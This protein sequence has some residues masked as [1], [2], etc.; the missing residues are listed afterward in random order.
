MSGKTIIICFSDLSFG[1]Q[2]NFKKAF[3]LIQS[4]FQAVD[5][6]EII[7]TEALNFNLLNH[8][9]DCDNLI[10]I[11]LSN[12]DFKSGSVQLYVNSDIEHFLD[13]Y[14]PYSV[15]DVN[16]IDL[17]SIARL[18]NRYPNQL[19][20]ISAQPHLMPWERKSSLDNKNALPLIGEHI[21]KLLSQWQND[22]IFQYS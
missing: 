22:S 20:V 9:D 1:N 2:N 21:N 14:I 19:A 3:H 5:T 12:I 8:F 7:K 4:L 10:L 18:T 16:F 15:H 17:F 13:Y 6:I 11:D